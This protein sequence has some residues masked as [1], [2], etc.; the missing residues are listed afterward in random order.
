MF[1]RYQVLQ[2]FVIS[3]ALAL[4]VSDCVPKEEYKAMKNKYKESNKKKKKFQKKFDELKKKLDPVTPTLPCFWW[5][6]QEWLGIAS[7]APV[8]TPCGLDVCTL[9]GTPEEPADPDDV[10]PGID[11]V[12]SRS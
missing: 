8:A 1:L 6:N 3:S 4:A 11:G 7:S 5:N 12:A 2:A 9:C 10:L